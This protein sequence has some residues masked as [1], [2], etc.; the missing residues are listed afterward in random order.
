LVRP[1]GLVEANKMEKIKTCPSTPPILP[2]CRISENHGKSQPTISARLVAPAPSLRH[3]DGVL[4]Q[5][6]LDM[7]S[8]GQ[9]GAPIVV[10]VVRSSNS[11]RRNSPPP[12]LGQNRQRRLPRP[13]H[14]RLLL[15]R[16]RHH[17]RRDH[18]LVRASCRLRRRCPRWLCRRA[19]TD[20]PARAW[21]WKGAT[22]SGR[23]PPWSLPSPSISSGWGTPR[24]RRPS[25]LVEATLPAA[26][27]EDRGWSEEGDTG[28]WSC[29]Q[30]RAAPAPPPLTPRRPPAEPATI[31]REAPGMRA[32]PQSYYKTSSFPQ[33]YYH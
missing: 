4:S 33:Y 27:M 14:G 31:S 26:S 16:L 6:V 11:S 9:G 22:S 21:S 29:R 1:S 12:D 5:T 30:A 17:Q 32:L 25:L 20:A 28:A 19:S 7:W 3:I 13:L 10:A 24:S 18:L 2:L 23:P 8:Q 15:R